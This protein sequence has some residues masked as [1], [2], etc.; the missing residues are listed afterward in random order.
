MGIIFRNYKTYCTVFKYTGFDK[1]VIIPPENMGHPVTEI[2]KDAFAGNN[3]LHSVTFPPSIHTVGTS[4]FKGCCHLCQIRCQGITDSS[5][6]IFSKQLRHF[7]AQAFY[8]TQLG[9]LRFLSDSLEI[10]ELCFSEC[11]SLAEVEFKNCVGLVLKQGA[12]KNSTMT[13]ISAPAAAPGMIPECC[14]QNCSQLKKVDIPFD[15]ADDYSFSGCGM[16]DRASFPREMLYVSEKAFDRTDSSEKQLPA[17]TEHNPDPA[18]SPVKALKSVTCGVPGSIKS[19][20]VKNGTLKWCRI[21]VSIRPGNGRFHIIG[22]LPD[23]QKCFAEAAYTCVKT[24]AFPILHRCDTTLFFLDSVTEKKENVI[25]LACFIAIC[26]QIVKAPIPDSGI[27]VV[28]GCSI[29]GFAYMDGNN[30]FLKSKIPSDISMLLGPLGVKDMFHF[31]ANGHEKV[32]IVESSEANVLFR[33][34]L[35]NLN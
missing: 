30:L 8:G 21:E 2:C 33:V 20:Y 12:F 15:I 7:G 34:F 18:A 4:A 9:S 31:A 29:N 32:V 3:I 16:L 26:S 11:V 19:L 6:S 35:S 13:R 23:S 1:D 24:S 10:G 5:M 25:G 22:N 14:F 28:G 17:I 27:G